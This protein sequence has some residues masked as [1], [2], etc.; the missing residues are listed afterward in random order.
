MCLLSKEL[1][2]RRSCYR[3]LPLIHNDRRFLGSRLWS[4]FLRQNLGFYWY[5]IICQLYLLHWLPGR[6]RFLFLVFC[7]LFCALTGFFFL[8][9][10]TFSIII[11]T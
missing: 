11:N 10:L 3:F 8:L 2:D 9:F 7:H 6:L 5:F 1:P 4:I